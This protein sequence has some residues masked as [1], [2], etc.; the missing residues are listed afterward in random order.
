MSER[1]RGNVSILVVAIIVI[2]AAM[3]LGL[4]R[5]GSAAVDRARADGAA[6]AAALAAASGLARGQS[7]P[8]A[9]RTARSVA[10]ANAA[11]LLTCTCRGSRAEVVV[12]VD[13]VAGRAAAAADP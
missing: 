6:D 5:L 9:C 4:A 13:G 12:E 1:S 2:G 11:R 3:A 7:P 8:A 10:T